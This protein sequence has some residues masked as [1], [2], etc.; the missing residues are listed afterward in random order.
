LAF[1]QVL[2][3]KSLRIDEVL[4]VALALLPVLLFLGALR[5]LDSYK[6]VSVR[7][8]WGALAAGAVAAA[9]CY[10]I[11]TFIFEQI[12]ENQEQYA[13]FGAPVVEE[14]AKAIFWVYLIS[15]A[16]VAFMVDSAICGFAIGTGFALVENVTYLQVLAERGLG[17]WM[18]RGFGTAV[19]HGGVAAIGAFVSVYLSES[20]QWR[21]AREFAPGIVTAI[22]LHS[23]FNQGLLSPAGSAAA[24][25]A[26]L[27]LIFIIVFYFSERSLQGWLSGK[28]DQDIEVIAMIA[29]GEFKRTP[30]GAYLMS[31]NDA[32]PPEVRGDMLTLLHLTIELS[33]RAKGN[34][35]RREAGLE[36]P[37]DPNLAGHLKELRYLE[38]SIGAT[39]ML[40]IRPLLSQTPRDLWEMHQL[41][42]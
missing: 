34:L 24:A 8:V 12:P 18:L 3:G 13:R 35:M 5:M 31:L 39:G 41:G 19:M 26:G 7:K 32:F 15:M 4:R 17:L 37:P 23:L 20:R 33:A 14:L 42:R 16:R 10:G 1:P 6:L 40:A 22:V 2:N 38:K 36:V 25:M 21:G 9:I 29:S 28:L 11:N 27:P 30:Q